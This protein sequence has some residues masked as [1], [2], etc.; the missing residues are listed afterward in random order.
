M[1]CSTL[2]LLLSL[3]MSTVSGQQAEAVRGTTAPGGPLRF[4]PVFQFGSDRLS[5]AQREILQQH[6]VSIG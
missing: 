1:V 3:A 6:A 4:T 5:S 2:A